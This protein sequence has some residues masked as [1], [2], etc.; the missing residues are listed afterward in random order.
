MRPTEN[1]R[2]PPAAAPPHHAPARGCKTPAPTERAFPTCQRLNQCD[3]RPMNTSTHPP[4]GAPH[5]ITPAQG[6]T[7]DSTLHMGAWH[8]TPGASPS[9]TRVIA[10][11]K[12][13]VTRVCLSPAPFRQTPACGCSGM[14]HDR[15]ASY[16][17]RLRHPITRYNMDRLSQE[18]VR[19]TPYPKQLIHPQCRA[20][21]LWKR[22][23]IRRKMHPGECKAGYQRY[24]CHTSLQPCTPYTHAPYQSPSSEHRGFWL[25]G[26]E[27]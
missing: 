19:P 9:Q 12:H 18:A 8:S 4:S 21:R 13:T 14:R 7:P 15:L 20:S 22:P 16:L 25:P 24:T 10:C 2:R 26:H 11:L 23:I 6:D 27:D 3:R 1:L 5:G 17:T